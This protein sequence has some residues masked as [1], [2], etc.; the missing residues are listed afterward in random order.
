MEP[1]PHSIIHF[2]ISLLAALI[3]IIKVAG[4]ERSVFETHSVLTVISVTA[5]LA[6][7]TV[8]IAQPHFPNLSRPLQLLSMFYASI[9]VTSLVFILLPTLKWELL[10]SYLVSL[11]LLSTISLLLWK[12]FSIL[13]SPNP[14]PNPQASYS[15]H[16]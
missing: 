1:S 5:I 7:A 12:R 15:D 10:V 14:P 6:Y 2:I 8:S 13:N 3:Q 11:L 4:N 9:A 16:V